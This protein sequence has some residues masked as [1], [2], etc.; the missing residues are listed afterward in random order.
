MTNYFY[1]VDEKLKKNKPF[2][3]VLTDPN[4][5]GP[6]VEELI[7]ELKKYPKLLMMNKNNFQNTAGWEDATPGDCVVFGDAYVPFVNFDYRLEQNEHF[8]NETK[9]RPVYDLVR[10]RKEWKRSILKYTKANNRYTKEQNTTR[11]ASTLE[12]HATRIVEK[13]FPLQKLLNAIIGTQEKKTHYTIPQEKE[14]IMNID[15]NIFNTFDEIEITIPKCESSFFVIPPKKTKKDIEYYVVHQTW[16]KIG[17][18]AYDIYE[19]NK[20]RRFIVVDGEKF[21]VYNGLLHNA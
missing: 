14:I 17:L 5:K 19:D 7:K 1:A 9:I 18:K 16:V 4:K 3:I 13:E 10:D 21:W 15:S 20:K 11:P 8:L 6:Y 2:I 12:F